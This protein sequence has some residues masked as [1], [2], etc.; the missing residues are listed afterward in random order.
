MCLHDIV[1]IWYALSNENDGSQKEKGDSEAWKIRE[2]EDIRVET[3]GQWT[4][5]MCIVD[6]REMK[7]LDRNYVEGEVKGD[8]G[9]WLQRGRGNRLDRCVGTPG[10]ELLAPLLLD[11]IFG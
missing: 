7:M 6:R 3:Q 1:C 8:T 10:E 11:K 2:A 4:R 9:G 5:G